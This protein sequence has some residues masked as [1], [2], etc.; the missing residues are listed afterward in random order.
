MSTRYNE[1]YEEGV[2]DTISR[3]R[4]ALEERCNLTVGE[5]PCLLN[6]G[7]ISGCSTRIAATIS[8]TKDRLEEILNG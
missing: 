1:G 3:I 7:H 8:I 2:A 5:N 4:T 6:R